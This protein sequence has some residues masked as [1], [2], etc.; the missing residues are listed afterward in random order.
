MNLTV[1]D[2]AA[3]LQVSEKTI[4]RWIQK[5]ILPAY[6]LQDQ[7]RFV[8]GELLQWA[9]AHRVNASEAIFTDPHLDESPSLR[10]S[11]SLERGGIYYRIEGKDKE[12]VI[13]IAVH[14]LRLPEDVDR[15]VLY[16]AVL[17]RENLASTAIGNG[18]AV[19][20]ARYPVIQQFESPAVGL[21]FIEQPVDFGAL[22][23]LPVSAMFL[24]V[25]PTV[26][27]HLQLLSRVFH[28]LRKPEFVK[29][30]QDQSSREQ[31]LRMIR[32]LEGQMERVGN[33]S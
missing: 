17:I 29:L 8:R 6:R 27:G 24:V 2:A 21:F 31:I 4:Y 20:H 7:Y 30:L 18:I 10:L 9:G 22:D 33:A 11:D 13:K 1:K 25:S 19:P 28:L 23:G 12:T 3:L 5:G 32:E 16:R 26:K 14:M 15:D